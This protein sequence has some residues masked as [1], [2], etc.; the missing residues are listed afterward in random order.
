[1][2]VCINKDNIKVQK[3]DITIDD[4][5]II[6]RDDNMKTHDEKYD[7]GSNVLEYKKSQKCFVDILNQG[8]CVYG[9]VDV[10]NNQ[11]ILYRVKIYLF[12]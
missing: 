5:N 11:R 7:V 9:N 6:V 1:M 4:D 8:V 2:Y 10:E 3:E 12:I